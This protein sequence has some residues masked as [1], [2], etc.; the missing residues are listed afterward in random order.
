MTSASRPCEGTNA[1]EETARETNA[2]ELVRKGGKLFHLG[3]GPCCDKTPLALSRNEHDELVDRSQ[4]DSEV[5]TYSLH[6]GE[7]K[8]VTEIKGHFGG[9]ST[10]L[11]KKDR[12]P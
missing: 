11:F 10:G 4:S 8:V 12:Q 6:G 2:F 3:R 7:L 1:S 5:V 9:T